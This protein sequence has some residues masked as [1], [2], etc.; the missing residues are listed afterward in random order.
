MK[1]DMYKDR[2]QMMQVQVQ[3]INEDIHTDPELQD[4]CMLDVQFNDVDR[5]AGSYFGN[6]IN[7]DRIWSRY[8]QLDADG[9]P[10]KGT[11]TPWMLCMMMAKKNTNWD[12]P[13]VVLPSDQ[14]TLTKSDPDGTHPQ[15]VT[16]NEMLGS[17]LRSLF[18][19]EDLQ[20][21]TSLSVDEVAVSAP[22]VAFVESPPD[23]FGVEIKVSS[24]AYNTLN[25]SDPKNAVFVSDN[26]N[27]SLHLEEPG[28][29]G[30]QD[31]LMKIQDENGVWKC[32]T[33]GIKDT[34]RKLKD[35][36]AK[37]ASQ[38]SA[39]SKTTIPDPL[40]F[41]NG[42]ISF[43][44][45]ESA[46]WVTRVELEQAEI[47]VGRPVASSDVPV[48]R[49]LCMDAEDD[50]DDDEK[51]FVSMGGKRVRRAAATE[52]ELCT[53]SYE[54]DAKKL[55]KTSFKS[56]GRPASSTPLSFCMIPYDSIV[57]KDSVRQGNRM[58]DDVHEKTKLLGVDVASRHDVT[59]VEMGLAS[60]GPLTKKAKSEIEYNL[61]QKIFQSETS[62]QP[63]VPVVMG[64]AV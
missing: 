34:G 32:Y 59:A 46:F 22:R 63:D 11:E 29:D 3:A 30:P 62:A 56:S 25:A 1:T 43:A 26:V 14:M 38:S 24:F 61:K 17:R 33:S 55:A 4:V 19:H 5:T 15:K 48:Y 45:R 51:E 27:T 42:P 36:N 41:P 35:V 12:A 58:I 37:V 2:L 39:P 60:D 16:L 20:S 23:G 64:M 13:A 53:G 28:R 31:L 54:R 40:D 52:G 21:G 8:V 18:R 44:G 49:S 47:P 6:N 50:D 10:I 9:K 57:S 7:D